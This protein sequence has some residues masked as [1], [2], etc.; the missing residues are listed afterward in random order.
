MSSFSLATNRPPTRIDGEPVRI[1][2]TVRGAFPDEHRENAAGIEGPPEPY[3][4]GWR[5]LWRD[6]LAFLRAPSPF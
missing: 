1:A 5:A 6:L 3:S 2:R 4:T